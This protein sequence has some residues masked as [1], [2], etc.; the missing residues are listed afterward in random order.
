MAA[1]YHS[2]NPLGEL[3]SA[4]PPL[5]SEESSL[6]AYN[7]IDLFQNF[8]IIEHPL[9]FFLWRLVYIAAFGQVCHLLGGFVAA[10]LEHCRCLKEDGLINR[11]LW[12]ELLHI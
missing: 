9:N 4:I 5:F 3:V 6:R 12:L 10:F 11:V 7:F 8:V 2:E 1:C